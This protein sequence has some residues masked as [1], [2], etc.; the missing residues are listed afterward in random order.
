MHNPL[1]SCL[2]EVRGGGWMWNGSLM[3]TVSELDVATKS[4]RQKVK[5]PSKIE[6]QSTG[7]WNYVYVVA[8][9][10]VDLH[11][12]K[13]FF[14]VCWEDPDDTTVFRISPIK[15]VTSY[16]TKTLKPRSSLTRR[17]TQSPLES[18]TL[19]ARFPLY[20]ERS[21]RA[22]NRKLIV[23]GRPRST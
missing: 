5:I 14:E 16:N 1:C 15:T 8:K 20:A 23:R 12:D 3:M 11:R 17:R 13:F 10:V 9:R 7:G 6:M 22:P 18:S 21:S 19:V 4:F 2:I